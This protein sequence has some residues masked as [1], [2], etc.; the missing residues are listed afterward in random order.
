MERKKQNTKQHAID[1][2]EDEAGGEESE[3][4]GQGDGSIGLRQW[5]RTETCGRHLGVRTCLS[6]W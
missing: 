6:T 3:Q 5:T 1:G 2:E 4:E